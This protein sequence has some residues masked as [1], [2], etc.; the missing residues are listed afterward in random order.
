VRDAAALS[1]AFSYH[2][3]Y[4]HF[5]ESATNYVDFGPQNSRGF[6]A[7]KVWLALRQ[8]GAAGYRRMI[9]DDIALAGLLA[10]V[11]RQHAELELWT[12]ELSIT[13][14]RCVPADLRARIGTAAVDEYLDVLNKEVLAR[15][16]KGGEAFVSN[17]VIRGHYVLRACVVNFHTRAGD[18]QAVADISA[19]M[20]RQLDGELRPAE[21]RAAR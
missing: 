19:R 20:G 9:A 14:W 16:Q 7:L 6:R 12:H 13:T 17:A 3:P 4:Y 1:K 8:A 21:L 18:M 15:M 11:V 10:G 2:P 5:G